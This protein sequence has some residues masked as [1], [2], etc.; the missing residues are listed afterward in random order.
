VP[1]GVRAL[2]TI[3]RGRVFIGNGERYELL[4]IDP[5]SGRIDM[6]RRN[7]PAVP[8][9]RA[10]REYFLDSLTASLPAPRRVLVR[11]RFMDAPTRRTMPFFHALLADDK[12]RLWLARPQAREAGQREW[13]LLDENGRFLG[14]VELP[15][16]LRVTHI[17]GGHVVGIRT[18]DDGVESIEVYRLR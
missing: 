14:S 4:R 16:G 18:D 17:S 5:G 12:G 15:S 8:L 13:E 6:L 10:R 1:Y 11:D 2:A 9:D 3:A 7:V